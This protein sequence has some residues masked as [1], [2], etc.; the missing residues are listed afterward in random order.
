MQQ[1]RVRVVGKGKGNSRFPS[2]MTTRHCMQ[3]MRGFGRAMDACGAPL[4]CV[5][6]WVEAAG[7]QQIPFGNDNRKAKATTHAEAD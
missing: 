2:G 1:A 5:G 3:R 7:E 4:C 6:V